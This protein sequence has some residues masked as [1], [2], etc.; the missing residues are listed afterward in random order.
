[1][2][3]YIQ[4][5]INVME[6]ELDSQLCQSSLEITQEP[7]DKTPLAP[8]RPRFSIWESEDDVEE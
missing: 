5:E 3:K 4:P 7:V 8:S 1:M 2:K 6:M